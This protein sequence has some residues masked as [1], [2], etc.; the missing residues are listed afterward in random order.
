MLAPLEEAPSLPQQLLLAEA[1]A[2]KPKGA[3]ENSLRITAGQGKT[4][5]FEFSSSSKALVLFIHQGALTDPADS[6]GPALY[7]HVGTT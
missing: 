5:G 2:Q 7:V 6:K 3:M 4:E 1:L